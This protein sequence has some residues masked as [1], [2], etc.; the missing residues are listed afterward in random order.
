[1]I[2]ISLLYVYVILTLVMISFFTI[3]ERFMSPLFA[4]YRR[5][6]NECAPYLL[7][8]REH[9]HLLELAPL[10]VSITKRD[11]VIDAQKR[12][13]R[14]FLH[15]L[16]QLEKLTFGPLEMTMP[17]W[18]SYDAGI[19][20]AGIFGFSSAA[21]RLEDW[22]RS[23]LKVRPDYQGHVPLTQ[24]I[25]IPTPEE[26]SWYLHTFSS[27][28]QVC[29]GAATPANLTLLTLCLGVRVFRMKRLYGGTQWRSTR[30]NK[31]VSLGPLEVIT[32]YTPNHSVPKTLTW[33]LE[34]KRPL[35]EAALINN[36]ASVAALPAT[37]MVDVDD[38]DALKQMQSEIEDGVRYQIVGQPMTRGSIV[39]V[40]V[41]RSE[42]RV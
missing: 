12:G 35:I 18:V 19:M 42:D 37:H 14:D 9:Q 28:N 17:K 7:T 15:L 38:E 13:N 34:L 33:R 31:F 29:M 6:F 10:G 24:F 4:H 25:S 40:P 3:I 27:L 1:M 41:R 2:E 30:L 23:A 8:T 16:Q 5:A 26:G 32:A 36:G 11:G 39:Q 22:V 20:P 21:P